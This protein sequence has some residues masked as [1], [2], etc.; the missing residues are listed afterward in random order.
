MKLPFHDLYTSVCSDETV[1]S[2][3]D[4]S[5]SDDNLDSYGVPQSPPCQEV[6]R[7][8]C[9]Q[10]PVQKCQGVPRSKCEKVPVQ[11]SVQIPRLEC[12]TIPQISCTKV[13]KATPRK[14]RY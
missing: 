13:A 14:V 3:N 7:Q 11:K 1:A 9:S 4:N 12:N 5:I 10:I 2:E 6:E 8:N